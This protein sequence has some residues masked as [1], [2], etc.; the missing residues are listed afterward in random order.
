MKTALNDYFT[1]NLFSTVH[2]FQLRSVDLPD[3]FEKAIMTTEVKK[4]DIQKALAEKN[5]TIVELE[6]KL[7]ASDYDK[8]VTLLLANG[9]AKGIVLKATANAYAYTTVQKQ[10]ST[11]YKALKTDTAMTTAALLQYVKGMVTT[12]YKGKYSLLSLSKIDL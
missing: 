5:T 4:Q 8:N 1:K 10:V 9:K 6:T 12:K 3:L 7:L 11:S 2:F